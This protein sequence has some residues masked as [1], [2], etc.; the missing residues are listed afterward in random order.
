MSQDVFFEPTDGGGAVINSDDVIF[1]YSGGRSIY[2]YG[3]MLA[4][5]HPTKGT[6]EELAWLAENTD[7]TETSEVRLEKFVADLNGD[8]SPE[9][10][11]IIGGIYYLAGAAGNPYVIVDAD[12]DIII[13]GRSPDGPRIFPKSEGSGSIVVNPLPAGMQVFEIN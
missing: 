12:D 5:K 9:R 4:G 11:F 6:Q 1:A 8:G 13:E 10:I 3:H 7:Y 2:M